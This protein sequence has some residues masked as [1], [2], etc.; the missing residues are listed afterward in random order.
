M[1]DNNDLE[2]N[3]CTHCVKIPLRVI[4]N[5]AAYLGG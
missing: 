1:L 2:E 4:P 5:P 3:V